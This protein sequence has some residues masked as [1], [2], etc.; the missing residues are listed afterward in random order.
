MKT[1]ICFIALLSWMP[2]AS[3]AFSPSSMQTRVQ[4]SFKRESLL[5][6]SVSS[7]IEA[8]LQKARELREQAESAET[9]LHHI[10]IEKKS[11][12]DMEADVVIDEIF[13]QSLKTTEDESAAISSLV[14]RLEE[15]RLST[16]M[17]KRVIERLHA[18]EISA[19]G[20]DHVESSVNNSD[21]EFK[22]VSEPNLDELS[23]VQGLIPRLLNAAKVIDEKHLQENKER[24]NVDKTHWSTGEL[25]KVLSEKAHFLGREHD[26]QFKQRLEE[27]YEAARK[28]DR[29]EMP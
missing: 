15:K 7:D 29:K 4:G 22:R 10:L 3:K 8:M 24:H 11:V 23:R 5:I 21:I 19:K 1:V 26:T 20:I 14:D 17:L 9:Q 2:P 12:K 16:T 6:L 13:P 28:K 27:Y 18:R 25:H